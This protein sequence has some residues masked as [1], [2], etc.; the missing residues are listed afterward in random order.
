[1]AADHPFLTDRSSYGY[2]LVVARVKEFDPDVALRAALDLFWQRGYE[3]TSM[4]DLVEHLGIGRAS[5]YATFGSK[6]DLYLKALDRYLEL[7]D[8]SP[9]EVLSQPGPVL[10]AVRALMHQYADEAAGDERRRGCFV[11]NTAIELASRDAAAA[12]RVEESWAQLEAAMESALR[13]ARAQDEL[14]VSADP[15]ALARFL[16][17][18]L[19]GLKVVGKVAPDSARIRDAVETSLRLLS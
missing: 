11:V 7:R 13:R 1:M 5:L 12:R 16:V 6:R 8:P 4:S 3:S 9:M 15:R 2:S 10:P 14:P 17:V 19:Q 18:T